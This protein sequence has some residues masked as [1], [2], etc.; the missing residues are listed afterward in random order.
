LIRAV[1]DTSVLIRGLLARRDP[2]RAVLVFI[3][4]ESFE[5]AISVESLRELRDVVERPSDAHD[6]IDHA[7]AEHLIAGLEQRPL[8]AIDGVGCPIPVRDRKDEYLVRTAIAGIATFIVS[9]DNDLLVLADD[10]RPYGVEVV[11]PG[12]FVEILGAS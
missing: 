7:I 9:V 12:R 6:R 1:V 3:A 4:L 10:L 5:L 2:S 11:T 8:V